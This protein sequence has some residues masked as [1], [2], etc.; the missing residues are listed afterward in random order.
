MTAPAVTT[1]QKSP[2]H[3]P[4]P[5]VDL[6]VSIVIPSIILMKFSGDDNH[7]T[8]FA[9]SCGETDKNKATQAS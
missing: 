6:L 8:S 7:F 9:P 5:L 1:T 3:K 2:G 4:R